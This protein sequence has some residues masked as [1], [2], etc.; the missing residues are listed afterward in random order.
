MK[1]IIDRIEENIAI[2]ENEETKEI[3][4][5]DSSLLPYSIHEGSILLFQNNK[6]QELKKEEQE[7]RKKV[8]ERFKKLRNKF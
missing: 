6:Y 3:K 7:K 8:E 4:E 2:L 1:W 5:I